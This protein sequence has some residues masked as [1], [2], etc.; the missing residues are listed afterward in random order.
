MALNPKERYATVLELVEDLEHWLVDE[1]VKAYRE[2][3]GARLARWARR[4]KP[5]VTA[6]AALVL[7]AVPALS[8]SLLLLREERDLAEHQRQQAVANL[9]HSLVGEA[10]ALRQARGEGYRDKAWKLL[11]QA[12]HLDTPEKDVEQLRQEAVACMGDFAGLQPTV[13]ENFES[14]IN[15]IALQPHGQQLALALADGNLVIRDLATGAEVTRLPGGAARVIAMQF[16]PDGSKLV[17]GDLGGTIKVWETKVAGQWGCTKTLITDPAAPIT[18]LSLTPD[19]KHLAACTASGTKIW[20]WN[21]ADGTRDT[22]FQGSQ[23]EGLRCLALNH[24]GSLLAAGCYRQGWHGI[25]VWD[26][27]SQQLKPVALPSLDQVG[28]VVFSPDGRYLAAACFDAGIVVYDTATFQR[29]LFVAGY[30]P[31]PVTFSPD[32]QLLAIPAIQFG[33][34]RLWN[35]TTNREVAALA[36]HPDPRWVA[37]R[38]DGQA[39]VTAHPRSVRIWNLVGGE[40]KLVLDHGGGVPDLAFS[41]DGKLL[42]SAGKDM[43]AAIWDPTT[44]RMLHRLT[45]FGGVLNAVAF[46]PDGRLLATGDR[47]GKIRIWEVGSWRELP[48]LAHEIGQEIWSVGFS[49]DGRYFAA[50]GLPGGLVLWRLELS[51]LT[52]GKEAQWKLEK[53]ARLSDGQALYL[54]FSPDSELLVWCIGQAVHTWDLEKSRPGP[55]LPAQLISSLIG[56][57]FRPNSR[58]AVLIGPSLTPEVWDVSTGQKLFSCPGG[59]S[60]GNRHATI[61]SV[62]ALSADGKWLA[63]QGTAVKVWDLERR[64]PLLVLPEEQ[65]TAWCLAWSPNKELLAVGLEQGG[66]AIWKV[67]KIRAQLAG[68]G[69]DW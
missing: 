48:P 10:R 23:G 18:S 25:L 47:G 60:N 1:P 26:V 3:A 19:G 61:A 30:F 54:C 17:T 15:L 28:H 35:V 53:M 44:G 56:V 59:E 4:H 46:S 66:I 45:G 32:S 37:F 12:L 16:A 9:Y 50:C 13:W 52:Q 5:L 8:L 11:S 31:M 36:H 40:E 39:L 42:A 14:D 24:Q 64:K 2:P 38:T 41:P 67:P 49:P 43:S 33:V 51:P 68:I 22:P 65:S 27:T 29:R 20:M 69:L 58:Q 6:A 62:I 63:Q 55:S 34:V 21:L 57:A 7:I